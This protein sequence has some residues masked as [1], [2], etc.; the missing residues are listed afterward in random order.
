MIDRLA[1]AL[2]RAR[3][4]YTE[5]RVER[6]WSSSV[7][8]RGRRLES[9]TVSEDQG[10]FVRVLN[11]SHGWGMAS[12]TSLD[13]FERM[14]ARANELSHAVRL[15]QAVEL[16]PV[17][18]QREEAILDLDG[19]VRGVPLAE[20]KRLVESYNGAM[21]GVSDSIVDT[22]AT[23][24]DEVNEYWYVNSE[25]TAL[26]E[27]RP[28]VVLSG[29]A[30]AR[31][32]G[33]IE[34]GLESIGLR[35]GWNAVQDR[36]ADFRRVAERAVQLL[37]APRVKGGT[38]PVI[39]DSELAGVFAHE[40]IGHLSEADFVYANPQMRDMMVLGR[41]FGK[42]VLTVGDDGAAPG[43]RGTLPF[44]DEGTPTRDTVLI[45][46]G[47][48]VGRLHSRETAAAMGEHPT[49]N[50][51]AIS[52]RH[53]PIVRMTNTYIAN[54]RGTLGDLINDLK[55]GVY[56]CGAFGGQTLLE[57]FSFTAAYGHMIRDG[58]V[59]EMVKDVVLAGNLFQTLDRIDHIAGDF[60]WNQMGGGCGKGG[61]SPLPVTEGAPHVRIEAALIGGDVPAAT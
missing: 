11:R 42:P 57:N 52:F 3:A 61:Q 40:A 19:D 2:T 29:T 35:R 44:D 13:Q 21:L 1:A 32:D 9:A 39:L 53:A 28:E 33:T 48:L 12:F 16:A 26:H 56:A 34:K 24:R 41:R 7:T 46:E 50:A 45:K 20:K 30:T 18:P 36:T 25:G 14:V 4:D 37:D 22:L 60:Q 47:V 49:G 5:I 6:L 10:G 58:H 59:A 31:R 43:L 23:Y 8:F 27:L 55:L 51:R 17:A 15:E 54:G 38:Y